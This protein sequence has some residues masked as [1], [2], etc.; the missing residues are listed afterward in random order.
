MIR[1]ENAVEKSLLDFLREM[2][3]VTID[4][5]ELKPGRILENYAGTE[6]YKN[7][8]IKIIV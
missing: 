7:T 8:K 5:K 4:I 2:K 6:E 3:Y 1:L